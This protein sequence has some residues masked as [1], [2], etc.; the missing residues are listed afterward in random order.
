MFP[1]QIPAV[2]RGV[3]PLCGAADLL[4]PAGGGQSWPGKA[5]REK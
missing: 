5:G 2:I 1:V 3:D 4:S